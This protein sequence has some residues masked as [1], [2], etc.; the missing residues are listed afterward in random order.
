MRQVHRRQFLLAAG[1]ASLSLS[2]P[3]RGQQAAGAR[4]I[5]FL[6]PAAPNDPG[7]ALW[8]EALIQGL[9]DLGWIP[10]RNIEI[11]YRSANGG[12]DQLAAAAT[13][14]SRLNVSVIVTSGETLILAAQ[15]A[16]SSTP[17]VGAVMGDPIAAG[18]AKTLARPG[19]K[20]TGTSTLVTGAIA[21]WLELLREIAPRAAR[22]A[23]I[24]NLDNPTHNNLWSEA[25]AGAK[26]LGMS[27]FL[28]GYRAP[29]E[30]DMLLADAT[31]QK[32]TA[33][34]VL[35][36]PFALVRQ[37]TIVEFTLKNRLPTAYL[38]REN[39]VQ[40]GL[41]SYGPSRRSNFRRAATFVDKI[42][43]GANPAELPIE[44]A[45]EFELVINLKTAKALGLKVPQSVL[46]RATEV[47]E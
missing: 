20:I 12:P 6:D 2:L 44:Q 13:E 37:A 19:G 25:E 11:E 45:R 40:G 21:K 14:M 34:L 23:V 35:P 3:A 22:M 10:G 27:V 9:R 18:F 29:S 5:G 43:R 26:S 32:A 4:R 8:R 7:S 38:F 17:I 46:L 16:N 31:R 39:V 33:L 41:I 28:L 24:R 1:A 36:D 15:K 42:L 47:I 30:I